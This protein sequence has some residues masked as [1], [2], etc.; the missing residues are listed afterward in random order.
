MQRISIASKIGNRIRFICDDLNRLSDERGLEA[1]I[2]KFDEITNVRV[3]KAAKSIIVTHNS[4]L[5]ALLKRL[6]SIEI[7][8]LKNKKEEPSKAEIYK[9]IAILALS[10]LNNNAKFNKLASLYGSINLLKAGSYE[11]FSEGLTSKTLEALAVGVSLARGDYGAANGTNLL[12]NLGEYIEES[13]VH[14]SDDLI[15]EL[16]KPSIKE[17][18]IEI[19]KD[20]KNELVLVNT[21]DI[22]KGDIVVVSTG[23]S[24]AIDGYIVEGSASIN[25]VSMTGEAQ[26]VKKE[27]GDLVMSGTIVEE[28]RIKIWA[29]LIGDETTTNRIKKYIQSSLNEKSNIGLKATKLA[30]KLVPVTLGLAGLSYL[31]NKN[32]MSMASVLQAD[33]SCALKLATPVAFKTSISRCGRDGILIK[34]AKAIEALSAADTFVFDKTGTL[35]Y[36]NLSVS[37]IYSFDENISP[38]ELLNLSA[39]AEE[40]Y[41]HP[42]AE[43]IV[44]AA[45]QRGFH[46]IHH[47]EVEFIV[48][49]GVKTTVKGKEVIIGSRHFLEDDEMVDFRA[50]KDR[51]DVLENSGPALLYIAYDKKLIGVIALKD[52]IR[53]NAKDCISKLKEYGVKEII[54]LSGDIKSKA[55]EVA[56]NLGIDRIFANCLPTDKAK[57]IENLRNSGKKVA[58]IGDG[59][60]DAPSLVKANVGISMSKGA[61]IAKA[62]AD[63]SLLKDDICSVAKVKLIANKTMDKINANFKATVGINSAILL[64]ATLGKLNPIQTAVLHNGTTIALLLNSLNTR[65]TNAR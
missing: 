25:Q 13:T 49:H 62:S 43:A 18:W 32:T 56:K 51:L 50:H 36:G 5:N 46:H 10:A 11:L 54:M 29:E 58:F 53:A 27:R 30:N 39:S 4:S 22:K 34:G 55:E 6:Q 15:K 26:P 28:G 44:K 19:K 9:S 52:E 3:N 42:V 64:G 1:D 37:E 31:I 63:I 23:E 61:D 20:G 65:N 24:I 2:L 60:N 48:A 40:H 8:K 41:F 35:T 7:K 57:I 59:I 21:N 17:A 47:E 16:A 38:N 12:L 14:K 45:R 33:Y